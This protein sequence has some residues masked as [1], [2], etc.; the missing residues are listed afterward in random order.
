M[1][2]YYSSY[3]YLNIMC[4][5]QVHVLRPSHKS[6]LQAKMIGTPE[7]DNVSAVHNATN[8]TRDLESEADAGPDGKIREIVVDNIDGE[9]I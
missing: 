8:A 7:P 1:N 5:G 2:L 9:V 6:T 3:A 4:F